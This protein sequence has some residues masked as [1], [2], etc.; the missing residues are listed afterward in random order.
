MI[1]DSGPDVLL[2]SGKCFG[3]WDVFW[4]LGSVLESGKCLSL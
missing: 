4:I 3:Y 2:D 1:L